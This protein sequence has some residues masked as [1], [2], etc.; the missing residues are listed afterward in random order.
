LNAAIPATYA[1][2]VPE[3]LDD[4]D[5]ATGASKPWAAAA[6]GAAIRSYKCVPFTGE[7]KAVLDYF[8]S[9][10]IGTAGENK[11]LRDKAARAICMSKGYTQAIKGVTLG[12]ELCDGCCMP[13]NDLLDDTGAAAPGKGGS[14]AGAAKCPPPKVRPFAIK[15]GETKVVRT[16][17]TVG[18]EC[19]VDAANI[20]Y[21]N[22]TAKM[23]KMDSLRNMWI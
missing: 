20:K 15:K 10:L 23:R 16:P 4:L 13:S 1:F 2:K 6:T 14:D 9:R 18:D 21:V 3:P 17:P 5:Y 8:N 7:E 22:Q 19:F 12:C 11:E